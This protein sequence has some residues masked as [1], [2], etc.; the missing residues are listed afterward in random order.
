ME[1]VIDREHDYLTFVFWKESGSTRTNL[2]INAGD[3]TILL[4][5]I[6]DAEIDALVETGKDY[7]EEIKNKVK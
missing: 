1:I 2:T 7:L 6:S 3:N 5:G 4:K